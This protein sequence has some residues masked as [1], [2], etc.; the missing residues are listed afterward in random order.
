[1]IKVCVECEEEFDLNSQAK[2]LVGGKFNY[3]IIVYNVSYL[4]EQ[5]I[6]I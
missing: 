6:S 4:Y 3:T 1:M 5:K 2:K